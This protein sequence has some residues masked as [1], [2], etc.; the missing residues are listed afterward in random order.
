MA[1]STVLFSNWSFSGR[2]RKKNTAPVARNS[3]TRRRIRMKKVRTI[4][5]QLVEGRYDMDKRLDAILDRLLE[6]LNV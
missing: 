6:T 5:R 4:R 2:V 1:G 3:H